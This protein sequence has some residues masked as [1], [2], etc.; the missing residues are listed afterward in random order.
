MSKNALVYIRICVFMNM[1][2]E[3]IKLVWLR[4]R[5]N[6]LFDCLRQVMSVLLDSTPG[7]ERVAIVVCKQRGR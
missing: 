1:F 5:L 2:K 7:R 6:L 4:W 3:L